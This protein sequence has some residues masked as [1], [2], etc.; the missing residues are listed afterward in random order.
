MIVFDSKR[1]GPWV[2]EKAGG[3]WV[4]GNPAIGIE[5]D[6]KLVVGVTYDGYTGSSICIHSRCDDATATTREF[7]RIIFDYPFNQLK[8]KR[9]TGLVSSNNHQAK[10]VDEKLGFK[11]EATLRDYFP[12]G[13][14]IVYKMHKEDCRFIK[15]N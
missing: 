10:R 7:Y 11:Y 2:C 8:V 12:D 15:D 4:E 5:K 13:D 1:I 9:L 14:A 3:R 6:G